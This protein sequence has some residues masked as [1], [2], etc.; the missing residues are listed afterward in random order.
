METSVYRIFI[1]RKEGFNSYAA[2]MLEEIR[3]FVGIQNLT[4]LRYCNRYDIE[5]LDEA[6]VETAVQRVFSEAQT[7]I[8]YRETI[9]VLSNETLIATEYLPG[10]YDLKAD[11][12][13]QCLALLPGVAESTLNVRCARVYILSGKLTA[14]DLEKIR[15]YLINPV[16]SRETSPQK[17]ATLTMKTLEGD[18]VPVITNFIEFTPTQLK[19]FRE[20]TG[21]AMDDADIAFL[22]K[23]F[24]NIKRDPTETEIR[25]LDTYWSDHCR[26]TTFNTI[27]DTIEI[28][29]GPYAPTVRAAL[30]SYSALRAEI[31]AGKN[32]PVTLM[33]MAVIGARALKKRGLLDDLEES[34]EINACSIFID[35]VINNADGEK[36]GT[37]S[38]LLMFKNETHNHPTEIEPFGGA[39]TCVG[40]AIRDP[41]SGRSWV[42]QSLRVTGAGDPTVSIDKTLPGKLPQI[43]LTRDAA[44]GFSAYGNQIGLTAGQI[45]EYYDP[46]F[47]A[48]RMELGAVI[49]A[50]PVS[51]VV[52]E[53]PET[54]DLV[55]MVGGA[56]GRDGIGGATG[57]S[58]AHTTESFNEASAEVQKGNAAEERKIQRLFRDPKV[59]RLIRRCNDFG[60]GGVSVAVGEL[61]P[62]LDIDLSSVPKKYEGLNG[63]E[64]AISESQER[65]AVVVRAKDAPAFIEAASRE[66][67][68]AA[69]IAKVTNTNRLVMRWRGEVIVD[70]DRDFLDTAGAKRNT[71]VKISHPKNDWK[72]QIA[73]DK[74]LEERWYATLSDLSVASQRGL[75]ERFDGSIGSSSV[76]FPAGGSWQSTPEC[77]MAARIPVGPGKE[78]STVSLMTMGYDPKAAHWSP[79]HAAQ[80]AVLESLTKILALGG[81]PGTARLTFQ[82]YFERTLTPEAWGKPTAALLGALHAQLE[83]GTA[84]VGGKD[85]MSGTFHDLHVPPTLVSFA[86]AI[87]DQSQIRGG[88]FTGVG[89]MVVLVQ[90]PWKKDNTPDWEIFKKNTQALLALAKT[91]SV[92]AAY[93]VTAGGIAAALSKMAF[94]NRIG[95]TLNLAPFKNIQ[96]PNLSSSPQPTSSTNADLADVLF[97]P[98]YGSLLLEVSSADLTAFS[99]KHSEVSNWKILGKTVLK[100]EITL[101]K[102]VISLE[103]AHTAWEKTLSQVFPPV[104]E[105]K[106]ESLPDWATAQAQKTP[107][108]PVA[109]ITKKA[110]PLVVLPVFPGTNGE[111]DMARAFELSGAD[112]RMVIFRNR[113][114]EELAESFKD[115]AKALDTAQIIAF[116]GGFSAGNDPEGSGKFIENVLRESSI[117][118]SVMN[119]LTARKG[120]ILGIGSGFQALVKVGL[121]PYGEIREPS[122]EMPTLTYNTIG[123]H[124]SRFVRTRIASDGSPWSGYTGLELGTIHAVP[125]SH[126]EGRVIIKR[127]LAK[128]L[129]SKGQVFSQYVDPAGKPTMTEPY[130]PNGSYFAIEGMTDETGRIL[131]KLGHSERAIDIEAAGKTLHLFKNIPGNTCQNIFAAGVRYFN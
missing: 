86:V 61:A 28:E 117:A 47:L 22:Q 71:S 115:L 77:G 33:D 123:R 89:N 38:W 64:L 108:A 124:I 98:L 83:A 25:V 54:G 31:Y 17:P 16:D 99:A 119:L 15:N 39:G 125:V 46:G 104:S 58:K 66:N 12:T 1:E 57:S 81:N 6:S 105:E 13:Q 3:S 50:T 103:K 113:T 92:H 68:N 129:F 44:A 127:D 130:N 35:V 19:A 110:N 59:T 36:T 111:Y 29:D 18:A 32:K 122:D 11:S 65:M 41:L 20:E 75:R 87:A 4:G 7:D 85:S 73:A 67:L 79:F 21:L 131:G 76:L 34:A 8:V 114:P 69:V 116:S 26:H 95:V 80:Y 128:E 55:I 43:T 101:E 51:S 102:T 5:G 23:H 97:A 62:S 126:G 74:S 48:K 84:S 52:R 24:Q 30:D 72:W 14:E 94:G 9:P 96:V 91:G 40:G 42:Y 106:T 2:Q 53:E 90:T 82:E 70:I 120:L 37:E 121:L 107:H 56:T 63:T 118:D 109:V 49:A 60:A 100:G 45:V 112:T 10:Q 27:L 93:P 88:A 78:T